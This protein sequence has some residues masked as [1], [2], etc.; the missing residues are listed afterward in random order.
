M[1]VCVC[2]CVCVEMVTCYLI[3]ILNLN[4]QEEFYERKL[5]LAD[6]EE[7]EQEADNILKDADISDVAF[8]VVG[9]P[10]G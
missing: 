7:V 8:L 5:I 1:C 4:L 6:R 3:F 10:F 2:V 9:D